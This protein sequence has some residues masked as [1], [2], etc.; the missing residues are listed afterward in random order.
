MDEAPVASGA[1]SELL[2]TLS[3]EIRTSLNGVLGLTGLLLDTDLTETQR[4][5]AEGVRASGEEL[6]RLIEDIGRCA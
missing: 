2:V 4:N 3:H 1:K 6:L 5:Y